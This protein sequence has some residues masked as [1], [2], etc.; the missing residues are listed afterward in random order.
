MSFDFKTK[1]MLEWVIKMPTVFVFLQVFKVSQKLWGGIIHRHFGQGMYFLHRDWQDDIIHYEI[2][3]FSKYMIILKNM[4][5]NYFCFSNYYSYMYIRN[6]IEYKNV[7]FHIV[8][9]PAGISSRLSCIQSWLSV[10]MKQKSQSSHCE[11]SLDGF[12]YRK[13]VRMC[14]DLWMICMC[15]SRWW[16]VFRKTGL[17]YVVPCSIKASI[18]MSLLLNL[19]DIKK[20]SYVVPHLL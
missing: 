10:Q 14:T 18:I 8:A 15:V 17:L 13:V 1:C 7:I 19:Q 9:L 16:G 12:F 11:C 20:V 6:F 5:M 4:K 2:V 3:F